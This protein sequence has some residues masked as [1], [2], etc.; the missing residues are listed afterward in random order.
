MKLVC[1]IS[2]ILVII[3]ALNWGLVGIGAFLG[4]NLNVVNLLLGS[5][6]QAENAVYVLVGLAALVVAWKGSKCSCA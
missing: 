6:A 3:G 5:S 1:V 2:K 4:R